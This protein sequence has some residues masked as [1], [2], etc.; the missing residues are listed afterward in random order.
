VSRGP[1]A[2][3]ANG[4]FAA[5]TGAV[6]APSTQERQ[7]RKRNVTWLLSPERTRIAGQQYLPRR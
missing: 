3:V 6:S 5:E 4:H 1:I 7:S 2:A